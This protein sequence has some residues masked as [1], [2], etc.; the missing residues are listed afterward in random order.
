ML[1]FQHFGFPFNYRTLMLDYNKPTPPLPASCIALTERF[2]STFNEYTTTTDTTL[3][4]AVLSEELAE[5][6]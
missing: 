4:A 6:K 1:F 2:A 3:E 5:C